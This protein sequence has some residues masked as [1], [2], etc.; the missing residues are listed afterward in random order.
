MGDILFRKAELKDLTGISNLYQ[1]STSQ[2]KYRQI[3]H[4][5]GE[6]IDIFH[7]TEYDLQIVGGVAIRF[8]QPGE[9]WLSHKMIDSS[10]RNLGIGTKMAH[11]E[12]EFATKNGA[13]TIRL[14]TRTDNFPIH[15]MIGEKLGFHQMSRWIR[16]R[17]LTPIQT[18]LHSTRNYFKDIKSPLISWKEGHSTLKPYITNHI[19]YIHSDKLIP[20]TQDL[21]VYTVL[22]LDNQEFYRTY[23]T[24]SLLEDGKIKGTAIYTIRPSTNECLIHQIYANRKDYAFYLIYTMTQYA[25]KNKHFFSLLSFK[26]DYSPLPILKHWV[27]EGHQM[28]KVPDWF[29][30]GKIL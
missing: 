30:F 18:S 1:I 24:V 5:I 13:K 15:W 11:Y 25:A 2:K 9:V 12:E 21:S 20:Y 14:A 19:D 29:V 23:K 6:Q 27:K 28:E 3:K 10:I 22:N 26:P 8:P 17:R 16:W 7:V 4:W